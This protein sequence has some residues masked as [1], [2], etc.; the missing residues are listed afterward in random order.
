MLNLDQTAVKVKKVSKRK[1]GIQQSQPPLQSETQPV[2][3]EEITKQIQQ[4]LAS[5]FTIPLPHKK[6]SKIK[7]DSPMTPQVAML[8]SPLSASP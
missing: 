3:L 8:S 5:G 1:T 4:E 6:R 2:D 7:P